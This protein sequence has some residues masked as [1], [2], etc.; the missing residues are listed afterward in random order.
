MD[1]FEQTVANKSYSLAL[2]IIKAYEYLKDVKKEF[3]MSKQL[4]RCGTSIGAQIR[5][6]K[7]A[8]SRADFLSKLSISLKEANETLYWLELLH[9][10]NYLEDAVFTSIHQDTAEVTAMLVSIVKKLKDNP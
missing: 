8:Q 3:V 2:R 1:T 10:S 9:D 5:E 7:F 6:A 4:L